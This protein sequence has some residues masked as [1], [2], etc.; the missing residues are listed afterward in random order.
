MGRLSVQKLFQHKHE[1]LSS[2]LH[3]PVQARHIAQVSVF[4]GLL[5]GSG[6]NSGVHGHNDDNNG[7]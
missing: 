4:P 7:T 5:W 6:D 2:D 3:D 1:E